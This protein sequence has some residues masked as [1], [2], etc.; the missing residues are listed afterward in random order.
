MRKSKTDFAALDAMTD[1]DIAA[2]VAADPDAAP[3]FES[4]EG[5]R[6]GRGPQ[7][8]PTKEQITLRLSPDVVQHFKSG[9]PGWQT[10]ID[11]TLKQAI[12]REKV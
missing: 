8:Q 7:K 12:E 9:G 5:F 2:Q 4:L 3:L 1:E 6:R 11:E 10:R